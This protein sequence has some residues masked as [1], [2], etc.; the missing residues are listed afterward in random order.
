MTS[1]SLFKKFSSKII[2]VLTILFLFSFTA[3][4][5]TACNEAESDINEPS[6]SYTETDDGLISNGLFN[7]GTLNL[8]F[9]TISSL[10]KTNVTGWSVSGATSGVSSGVVDV[11]DDGWARL[12]E[13]LYDDN[14]FLTY[15]EATF[16]FSK[17]DVK[18]ALKDELGKEPTS[19]E[20][21]KEIID[22]Y[23]TLN[24][25]NPKK[26]S[27]E[28]DDKIFMLNNYDKN[29]LGHGI[30]QYVTSA[31]TINLEKGKYGKFTV[32]VKTQNL[33]DYD[34]NNDYGAYVG[35]NT[36]FNNTAQAKYRIENIITD[37]ITENNGW[38]QYTLFVKADDVYD[39]SV[40]LVLGL[41]VDKHNAVEGTA[42]FDDVK[43]EYVSK[44][45]FDA[46]VIEDTEYLIYGDT[47]NDIIRDSN[48]SI[49]LYDMSLDKYVQDDEDADAT[50]DRTASFSNF[51]KADNNIAVL[52]GYTTSHTGAKGDK[53]GTATLANGALLG[54]D[55]VAD[56]LDSKVI[57]LTNASYTLSYQLASDNYFSV[58]PKH[59]VYVEFYVKNELSKFASS[60]ITFDI[61]E[62]YNNGSKTQKSPAIT[63][64]STISKDWTKVSLLVKN[65]FETDARYF[66]IDVVIGPTDVATANTAPEYASGKVTITNPLFATGLTEQLNEQ[67][68]ENVNYKLYTLFSNTSNASIAL[69]AGMQQ[70]F[71][72]DS[73]SELYDM[74]YAASD[75]GAIIN[76]PAI[77]A[78]YT[79]V[80][81][82]H[83]YIVNEN[84]YSGYVTKVND[85]SGV[86]GKAGS[87]AGLVNT[88]Y[89]SNYT[90]SGIADA[91]SF[92]NGDTNIQPLMIYNHT[93][94]SYGYISTEKTISSSAYAKIS[95]DVRVSEGA[96]AYIYLVDV[97][98]KTKEVMTFDNDKLALPQAQELAITVTSDM[99][100]D[101][102]WVTVT[103]YI[104][105]GATAKNFRL[106]LWNGEREGANKSSG[107]VFFNNIDFSLSGAFTEPT[108]VADAFTVSGNPL[109]DI[110]KGIEPNAITYTRKLTDLEKQF[111]EEQTDSEKL[112]SYKP[113]YVWAKDNANIYAIFNTIDPVEV[114]PYSSET[115]DDEDASAGCTAE[116]DPSTFWLSFSSI[117]LGVVLLLAIIMLF[118]KNI[119][120]RR[121]ANASDAKSHYKIVSRS[122]IYKSK[123]EEQTSNDDVVDDET[124]NDNFVEEEIEETE[125]GDEEQTD[126]YIYGEVQNFGDDE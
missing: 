104:A 112:V 110:G 6:Y 18:T 17:T 67:E 84:E 77:P 37:G 79:G 125:A 57:Q 115:E 7:Y 35:L 65:N 89:I 106:E 70:D 94:D 124:N 34:N 54:G 56:S 43:F 60:A 105:T 91:L 85:R 50:V 16:G 55:H 42:Y 47:T 117:V 116:T 66:Y 126:E 51:V 5:F 78:N 27:D 15:A 10:P 22:S 2:W 32:W 64:I 100:Q 53:F 73:T 20:I 69:Y 38:K 48:N 122:R 88:K 59:Y 118:V 103:F 111:N 62:V 90:L 107:F 120:R 29:S 12:I 63:S 97:S 114:D 28:A 102:D 3:F 72:E 23:L 113:T 87:Y 121:K 75:I 39:T 33:R 30:N 109:Y 41:G 80:T 44:S 45:D 74:N 76:G 46:S 71:V 21:K 81:S 108:D 26:Y 52:G 61:F 25:P 83:A 95:V 98:G 92:K 101:K 86:N 9:T 119:R 8:D 68:K 36:S 11:T 13:K 123:V 49:Y 14:D 40:T 24:V 58:Q 4:F 93:A 31:S 19:S 82:N 99:L 96:T 1:N